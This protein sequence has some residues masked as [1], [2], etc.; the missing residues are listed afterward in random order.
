MRPR[1]HQSQAEH[2]DTGV[3][4]MFTVSEDLAGERPLDQRF[5][6]ALG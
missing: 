4:K 3:R 6:S 2:F 1:L 5:A